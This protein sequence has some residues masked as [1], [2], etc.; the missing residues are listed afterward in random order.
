M[1]R[2]ILYALLVLAVGCATG[3]SNDLPQD[4]DAGTQKDLDAKFVDES[5]ITEDLGKPTEDLPVTT[6]EGV[7]AGSGGCTVNFDCAGTSTPVCNT[8]LGRCVQ[9]MA[10]ETLHPCARGSYCTATNTC[11]EGCASDLDC[12]GLADGGPPLSCSVTRQC[13]APACSNDDNCPLGNVCRSGRCAA[14]C[15]ATHGCVTGQTCCTGTCFDL[16]RDPTHCG[17]CTTAC[18]TTQATAACIAGA[19]RL[20]CTAGFGNCN[21]NLADGCEA[22]VLSSLT[23]CGGCGMACTFT[24][25]MGLCATGACVVTACDADFQDCDNN[26]ANGCESN[27]NTDAMNC[28][29]CG[30][31]CA[32]GMT[33]SGGVCACPTGQIVC[34]SM[35]TNVQSDRLNC[36]M[37]NFGCPTGQSCVAGMCSSRPLYHG[38]T[39]PIAGCL[40]TGYNTTAATVLGGTYPYNTGDSAACR[41]WKLAAT[42]CTTQPLAYSGTENFSCPASGGFTDPLFGTYCAVAGQYACSSC[43]GSCNAGGCRAGSNTLRNCSGSETAQ[44]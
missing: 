10:G 2:R 24:R 33:C 27:P 30:A 22:S 16:Q 3:N 13:T 32:G 5:L 19:C 42:V 11:A 38:W 17:T 9:C 44:P 1:K 26:G 37:C 34:A 8:T 39:C 6:D 40:T 36:G 28:G 41:A 29:R 12:F 4:E 35:C 21:A 7:D 31:P 15:S 43:P 23:N 25:G 18:S 14:G 20:T